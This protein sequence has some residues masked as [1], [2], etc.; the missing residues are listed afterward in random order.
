MVM[1]I[2]WSAFSQE[3]VPLEARGRWLGV[4]MLVNGLVGIIAP[5][6]GGVIWNLNPDYLWWISL[7][8]DVFL[9]LPLMIVIGYSV[10]KATS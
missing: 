8:C 3:A 9:V 10:S 4:N 6:I 5:I 2:G 1:F 7:L